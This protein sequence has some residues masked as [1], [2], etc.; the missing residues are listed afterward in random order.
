MWDKKLRK[1]KYIPF[2]LKEKHILR[3]VSVDAFIDNC[4][5]WTCDFFYLS[6]FSYEKW[7]NVGSNIYSTSKLCDIWNSDEGLE[8]ILISY[9]RYK[10]RQF[11][12]M[13]ILSRIPQ[14]GF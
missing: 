4:A 7:V 12:I 3:N 11:Q 9:F 2:K 10:F 6:I 5:P 14:E 8:S 1:I 13:Q